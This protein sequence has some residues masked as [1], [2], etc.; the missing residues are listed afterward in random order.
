MKKWC[1]CGLLFGVLLIT[2][3]TRDPELEPAPSENSNPVLPADPYDYVGDIQGIPQYMLFSPLNFLNA[4]P[5]YNPTT[6]WGA[7]LGRVLFY[8]V[9]LSANQT[10]SCASCHHQS[11]A[12][13]DTG[14]F[15]TGFMGGHT[16]RSAMAI[17]NMRFSRTF[18]W[19]L[20]ANG[21]ENQV[22]MP[23]ENA[24]EM[25]MD[26]TLLVSRV[27][28]ASYYPPLFEKAFGTRVV[29]VQR[30]R[31]ALAQFLRSMVSYRSKYDEGVANGFANFTQEET[32]G[33]NFYFSG[34]FKCNHC[35]TT[36]NFYE[37]DPRNNGLESTPTDSGFSLI[38][39]D[40]S[41]V[42][43]FRVPTLRNI[44]LTAPYM[45]DGRFRT[46]EEV[47]EH[48]NTGVQA[49]PTLD[50]RLTTNMTVGGPPVQLNMSAYE[51]Q[52][53]V[54]FLGTLTDQ[55]FISDPKFSDPFV[56]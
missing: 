44:M 24:L 47:L 13:A 26:T 27:V 10:I 30:I 8:D 39:G 45:H 49:S 43:K 28:S 56:H 2:Q 17:V 40:P 16:D 36:Q 50:D 12:F 29:T 54:A 15:S 1:V 42:G 21:L 34:Q 35:H 20:R 7:T 41:D 11:H 23:I 55:S 31:Y 4:E 18:F 51:K 38:T 3:C 22:I 48:Y 9:A 5:A 53:L 25:G 52:A 19:D 14:A 33:M 46:M 6:N 32:D 37:R